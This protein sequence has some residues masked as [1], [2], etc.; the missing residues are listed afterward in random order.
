MKRSF[1]ASVECD[2]VSLLPRKKKVKVVDV[3]CVADIQQQVA[4]ACGLSDIA[5]GLQYFDAKDFNDWYDL[6]DMDEMTEETYKLKLI[7][8][9]LVVCA[10]S[11]FTWLTL[12]IVL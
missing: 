1:R 5:F 7:P 12:C 8:N 3:V 9:R 6:D 11:L 2:D 10:L 4:S